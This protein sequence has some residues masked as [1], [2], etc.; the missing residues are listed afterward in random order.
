MEVSWIGGG[1]FKGNTNVSDMET[2]RVEF[3]SDGAA[4]SHC[5]GM[6]MNQKGELATYTLQAVGTMGSNGYI[7][8]HGTVFF[9]S[10][11]DGEFASLSTTVGV[12]AERIDQKGN[13]VTKILELK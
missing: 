10:S 1:T 12:F 11:P 4:K 6:I 8:N 13:A 7:R 9:K 2:V 3:G 5:Q